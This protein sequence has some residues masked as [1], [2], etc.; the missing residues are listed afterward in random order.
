[1]IYV[2]AIMSNSRKKKPTY[3][4]LHEY[5]YEDKAIIDLIKQL[6]KESILYEDKVATMDES[7]LISEEYYMEIEY[8]D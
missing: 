6:H 5:R 7:D 3:Q 8:K 4:Y 2:I 1:M